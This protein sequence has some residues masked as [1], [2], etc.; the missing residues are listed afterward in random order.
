MSLRTGALL[1]S[2]LLW[3]H[4]CKGSS[5]KGPQAGG[6]GTTSRPDSGPALPGTGAIPPDRRIAWNPGIVG[7]IPNRTQVCA[8]VN[9]ATYGNGTTDATS[10]IQSAIDGCSEGQVVRLPAGSY[11]IDATLEI[12]KGIVLRGDGPTATKIL[13]GNAGV[14]AVIRIGSGA[15]NDIPGVAVQSGFTKG[16]TSLTLRDASS[17]NVGQIVL[18]D[19]KEDPSLVET[20][21]CEFFKRNVGGFRSLGQIFEIKSKN[22]NTVEIS[23]PLYHEYSANLAPELSPTNPGGTVKNAGVEDLYATRT[24]D[25]GG[26]GFIIHLISAAYSW[27]KNVET[28]KVSGRHVSLETCYRCVLRD[29]YLHD[30]WNNNPGGTAY[31]ASLDRHSSDNLIENNVVYYLNIPIVMSVSSGGNV[32][33]Y[34]YVD[35]AILADTPAWQ[36]ADIGTHCSFPYMELIEGNWI[37]HAATDNVHGGAGYITFYRNYLSGQH[38]SVPA[39]GNVVSF[40]LEANSMYINVV[41]NVLWKQGVTGIVDTK[42]DDTPA[43]YRLGS[44]LNP[45]DMC[46]ND[47]R[48]AQTLL[49]HGNFDFI[50]NQ[51][52]WDPN[53]SDRDLPP[54]LYLTAKPAFFGNRPWPM[55]DP[56]RTPP[57]GTLPAKDRFD[58]ELKR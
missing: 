30:A 57:L 51:V 8:T 56:T 43:L 40:D 4:G 31:G 25:H 36:M 53:I 17:F 39:T 3:I 2:L 9:A 24:S 55:A 20:G 7:G 16:S 34:N 28:E 26:Q 12:Q 42:C 45:G 14:D 15:P 33:A 27:V 5:G 21:D 29:S 10:A 19:Q 47:A 58:N 41:G 48:V 35:D 49:R 22:G 18:I 38:L 54:S 37:A 50:R 6:G 13:L 52:E 46:S 11:R 23:S 44:Y 32:I 1:L